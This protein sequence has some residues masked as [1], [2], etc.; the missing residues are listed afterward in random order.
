MLGGAVAAAGLWA[1][2]LWSVR[3]A[4]AAHPPQGQFVSVQPGVELHY[5]RRGE[6]RPVVLIHGSDGVLQDFTLSVFDDLAEHF[7]VIAFDRPGHGY[8]Q[9]PGDQRLTVELNAA[10]IRQALHELAVDRPVLVG[11]SYGGAVALRYAIEHPEELAGVVHLAGGAYSQGSVV[12]PL[13]H[14]PRVPFV[15]PLLTRTL[16]PVSGPVARA[17]NRPAFHP[18][19]VPEEWQRT[20]EAFSLRPRQ[21]ENFAE[22]WRA[23]PAD[24][25]AM[26]ASYRDIKLPV[27]IVAG[28]LDRV[29]PAEAHGLRLH[30]DVPGSHLIRVPDAGHQL[31]HHRPQ[32]VV[33]AVNRTLQLTAN[34]GDHTSMLFAQGKYSRPIVNDTAA[35]PDH[36]NTVNPTR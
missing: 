18:H 19:P 20:I 12:N 32:T 17:M 5:V 30:R 13:F 2:G 22:E 15:G 11:H 14:A 16:V 36:I 29:A 31:H 21:F 33:E 6:G 28:R 9:R 24:L 8:S 4:E 1:H 25:R 3:R 7:D 26:E 10:L 35:A 34:P 23:F 27:T